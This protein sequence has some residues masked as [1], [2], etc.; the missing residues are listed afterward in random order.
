MSNLKF[1][2]VYYKKYDNSKINIEN[3]ILVLK[4]IVRFLKLIKRNMIIKKL[5]YS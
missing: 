5:L 1:Y 4:G 3:G 2:R